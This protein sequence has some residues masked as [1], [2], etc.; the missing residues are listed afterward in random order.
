M[1]INSKGVKGRILN[2]VNQT[3]MTDF[4]KREKVGEKFKTWETSSFTTDE[5]KADWSKILGGDDKAL[6]SL[7]CGCE[8][9]CPD[10]CICKT[11]YA[12]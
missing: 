9:H 3:E 12:D 11:K 6:K 8:G 4:R 7:D 2:S 5:W 1:G 10:N